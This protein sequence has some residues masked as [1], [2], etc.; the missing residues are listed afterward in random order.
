MIFCTTKT[1]DRNISSP[2]VENLKVTT[3]DTFMK[4]VENYT[5]YK[6]GNFI[7][8][9]WFPVL[10]PL[11]IVGNTFSFIVMMKRNNRKMSTCICMAAIS[12]NDNL[13]MVTSFYNFMVIV[14]KIHRWYLW[15]CKVAAFCALFALQN[16]TFQVLAMTMDKYIAI[17]WPH[18]A[19]TYS[20]PKRARMITIG[21]SVCAFIYNS[22]HFH[23]THIPDGQCLAYGSRGILTKIYS[24]LSFVLNAVIPFSLLIYMNFVIVK[25]VKNS[26]EMFRAEISAGTGQGM[27]TR[28]KTMKSAENQLTLMLLSVTMLFLILLC[29]TYIRFIYLAFAA[30]DTPS[31]YANSMLIYQIS[32]KLYSTNSGINFFLYCINGQKFRNDLKEILFCHDVSK[33]AVTE[34]GSESNVVCSKTCSTSS[35]ASQRISAS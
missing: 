29:P 4:Q 2:A 12:V 14:L 18:K 10:I 24:W 13:M 28:E 1:V 27:K 33:R 8:T 30:R 19:A 16:S 9:Y 23:L 26:R 25:A 31:Q 20:T 3:I 5:T 35:L 17:K 15:V 21:S 34:V 22:P 32:F 11:G 6:I 7:N